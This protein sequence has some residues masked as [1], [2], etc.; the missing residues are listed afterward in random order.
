MTMPDISSPTA[1]RPAASPANHVVMLDGLRA[2]AIGLVMAVHAGVPGLGFGWIGVDLFFVLSGFLIT[3]LLMKEL[4]ATGS[5]DWRAFMIR[6]ALRLMPA[7]LLYVSL[8]TVCI[9]WWP[10]SE[11][12]SHEG[13]SAGA[14][15]LALWTYAINFVPQGGIWNGQI[16]TVHLWSLAV[17]QQYYLLWPLWLL[18]M[19][20]RPPYLLWAAAVTGL[21]CL[22]WF[23]I[24]PEGMLK[25]HMLF[26]RGF[27][28]L[29]AS[30]LAIAAFDRCPG[31]WLARLSSAL[32]CL[33]L[34]LLVAAP[35][36]PGYVRANDF[37]LL[38]LMVPAFGVWVVRLWHGQVG[39]GWAALLQH[40]GLVYIG[41][42]SYGA[43]LYHELARVLVWH[44][45]KPLMAG[46]PGML[47]FG[48]RLLV[49]VLLTLG[50]AALSYELW[51]KR[52]LR[53][54]AAY[55][56]GRG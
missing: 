15:T 37:Q 35:W 21:I 1:P 14:Y 2:M 6:R 50:L 27:S 41:K 11:R 29:L 52:F 26:T 18:A 30:A 5:I 23:L 3:T 36:L 39:A 44:L 32:G 46:W 10:G 31:G 8:I 7:Y 48:V 43:Y 34:G 47:G 16:L 55:R 49:Y 42:I 45:L 28:L 40:P 17:E 4:R 13:W 38:A 54:S 25:E 56:P 22:C 33:A 12:H 19:K 9:W 53:L 24:L 20:N 51:E